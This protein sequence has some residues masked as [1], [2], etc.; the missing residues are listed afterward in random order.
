MISRARRHLATLAAGLAICALVVGARAGG[1]LQRLENIT[2]DACA[3]LLQHTV[4][5]D[6]V[7]V[8]L[9]SRSLTELSS[10]PWP[11]RYHATA[12]R[13]LLL[14]AP[15]KLFM[16]IDFSSTSN[17]TDDALLEKALANHGSVPVV[18][19]NSSSRSWVRTTSCS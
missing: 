7:I 12:L 1:W 6:I 13:T 8:G 15:R 4:P 5:S 2:S 3:G 17:P 16:D 19:P 9:D 18:Y 10:W 14:A 11:R